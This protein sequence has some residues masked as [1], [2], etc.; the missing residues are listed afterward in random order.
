MGLIKAATNSIGGG[1]ADQWLEVIEP[2]DLGD[3]TVMT[4]GVLVRKNEKRQ[5]NKKGTS[6]VI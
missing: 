5:G 3:N 6:D 2:A 4:T 1:L